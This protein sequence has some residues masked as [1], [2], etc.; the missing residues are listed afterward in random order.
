MKQITNTFLGEL[1]QQARQS[2]RLRI[3][4]NLHQ[5]SSDLIQR[6]AIAMEPD[7][8][9][10]PHRHSH[11]WELLLPLRGRFIVLCFDDAGTVTSRT[12]LGEDTALIEMPENTWHAVLSLDA[13]G[14]IFE[15][16]RGPYDAQTASEF[17]P[18]CAEDAD[19]KRLNVWY[20]QAQVGDRLS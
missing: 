5:E 2:P 3:N 19:A 11:S 18:W 15:V 14:V 10:R 8:F 16:K 9:V 17:A 4:H 7:T 6:L 13:G 12:Q 1:S 20:A